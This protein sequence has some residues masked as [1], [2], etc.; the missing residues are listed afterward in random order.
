MGFEKLADVLRGA[1]E[2]FPGFGRR[3]KE[4]LAV[5]RWDEAVGAQIAKHA[6]ALCVKDSVLWVEVDHPIWKSELLYRKQQILEIL[7]ERT[8]GQEAPLSDIL[9]LDPFRRQR[10]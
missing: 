1:R 10:N 5:G 2:K 3:L 9:F 7:N 4:A 6:R 8:A